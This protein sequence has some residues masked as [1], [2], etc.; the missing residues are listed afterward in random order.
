[1]K[2][3]LQSDPRRGRKHVSLAVMLHLPGR[4]RVSQV[5]LSSAYHT[6]HSTPLHTHLLL[7]C[8]AWLTDGVELAAFLTFY[9]VGH[10]RE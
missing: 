10:A 3:G 8:A 1:M 4:V 5:A 7:F 9:R 2:I 6:K